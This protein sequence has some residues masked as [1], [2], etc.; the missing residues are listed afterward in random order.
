MAQALDFTK[1]LETQLNKEE[2]RV[3][4]MHSCLE[5]ALGYQ[6][7]GDTKEMVRVLRQGLV[8]ATLL[9]S[10]IKEEESEPK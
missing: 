2:W 4:Q 9:K 8:Y 3:R 6:A 1:L 5:L 7:D 10:D